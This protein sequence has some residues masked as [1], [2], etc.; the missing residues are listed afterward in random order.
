MLR[1][2]IQID[3]R[4]CDGCGDCVPSCHE[5]AIEIIDGKAKL[6]ADRYC[7]GF[8][9]CLGECPQGAITM[10]ER[11]AEAYDDDAVQQRMRELAPPTP[12][13]A[14][15]FGGC[16]GSA[17]RSLARP[18]AAPRS[19][20]SPGASTLDSA[21]QLAHWPV[22]IQLLHPGAP[23]LA[24]ADLVLAADCVPVAYAGF[25]ERYLKDHAVA[26]GCPKLDDITDMVERLTAIFAESRPRS[27]TVVRME[28]P[29]CGGIAQ[30]AQVAR[31]RAGVDIPLHFDVIGVRGDRLGTTTV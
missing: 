8:G 15:S 3:D 29:C 9:D 28:V 12:A 26:I 27:V 19:P 23:F 7:D 13:P 2:I 22:Q 18:T 30:A 31:E 1:K 5:G 14:P 21:S 6:V 4:L 11:E 25:H 16:P 10:I 24:G 17:E 20:Q